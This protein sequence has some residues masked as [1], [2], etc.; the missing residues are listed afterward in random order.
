MIKIKNQERAGNP[1]KGF[2]SFMLEFT[3]EELSKE[4][5]GDLKNKLANYESCLDSDILYEYDV[6][7]TEDDEAIIHIII[8][9]PAKKWP[10][11]EQREIKLINKFADSFVEFYK[12]GCIPR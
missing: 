4:D 1:R 7:Y 9:Y 5:T 2:V 10:F 11:E 3:D 6:K 12:E 8:H